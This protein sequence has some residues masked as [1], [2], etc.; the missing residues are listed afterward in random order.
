MLHVQELFSVLGGLVG[1]SPSLH[2]TPAFAATL[3][4]AWHVAFVL[5]YVEYLVYNFLFDKRLVL[6]FSQFLCGDCIVF[7]VLCCDPTVLEVLPKS[8]VV[9]N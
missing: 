4:V 9:Y 3:F 7:L 8:P 6:V 2:K 5:T 1:W